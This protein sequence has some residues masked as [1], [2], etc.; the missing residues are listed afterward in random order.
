MLTEN[1]RRRPDPPRSAAELD[2]YADGLDGSGNG[3]FQPGEQVVGP[4][5]GVV[6]DGLPGPERSAGDA[7]R[8][9]DGEP[10]VP[11][12]RVSKTPASSSTGVSASA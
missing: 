6:E 10:L 1:G 11:G 7:V 4:N 2:G 8:L 9:Q 12:G 5:L 3:M